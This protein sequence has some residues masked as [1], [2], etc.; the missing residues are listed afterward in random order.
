MISGVLVAIAPFFGLSY[1]KS[2]KSSSCKIN[3]V[4]P[5]MLDRQRQH[6]QGVNSI[7]GEQNVN[8]LMKEM[9]R[10]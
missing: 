2:S 1:F 6:Q 3:E 10:G 9:E 7:F 4:N 5:F 8:L